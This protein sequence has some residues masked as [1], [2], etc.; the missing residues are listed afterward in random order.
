MD[1]IR[2]FCLPD[3]GEGSARDQVGSDERTRAPHCRVEAWLEEMAVAVEAVIA[4]GAEAL[5]DAPYDRIFDLILETTTRSGAG[6][7]EAGVLRVSFNSRVFERSQMCQE[8][9]NDPPCETLKREVITP[10]WH[11]QLVH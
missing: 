4:L 3:A 5:F 1:L 11:P 6:P 7:H 10:R 2:G 9:R 8:K